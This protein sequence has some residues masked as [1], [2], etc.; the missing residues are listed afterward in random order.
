MF[1]KTRLIYFELTFPAKAISVF[2]LTPSAWSLSHF[3]IICHSDHYLLPSGNMEESEKDPMLAKHRRYSSSGPGVH[4]DEG[5]PEVV[6][7]KKCCGITVEPIVLLY[8]LGISSLRTTNEQF[9]YNRFLDKWGEKDMAELSSNGSDTCGDVTTTQEEA[10]Q[11]STASFLIGYEII[12]VLPGIL[13]AFWVGSRSDRSGRKLPLFLPVL[14]IFLRAVC[15]FLVAYFHLDTYYLFVGVALDGM[16]GA[17]CVLATTAY[18]YIADVT[19]P[20]S[21]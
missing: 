20:K 8:L 13:M 15:S 11:A 3:D 18:A 6:E 4:E 1:F 17:Q 9:V 2:Y 14:G 10:A 12:L 7:L 5:R 19:D 16:S 21:R